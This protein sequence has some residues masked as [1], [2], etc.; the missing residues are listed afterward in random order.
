MSGTDGP[1][2]G[3]GDR[4]RRILSDQGGLLRRASGLESVVEGAYR[5]RAGD[6]DLV[7]AAAVDSLSRI[8]FTFGN[9]SQDVWTAIARARCLPA[10]VLAF[11]RWRPRHARPIEALELG[12][13]PFVVGDLIKLL[14][15]ALLMPLG[16]RLLGTRGLAGRER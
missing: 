9:D 3:T 4:I 13:Y 12:L 10:R 8:P 6:A 14:A 7:G 1:V 15:A 16:W 5:I 2:T 11:S